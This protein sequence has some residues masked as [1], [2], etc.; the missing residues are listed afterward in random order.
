LSV[1]WFVAK[2][3]FLNSCIRRRQAGRADL[4]DRQHIVPAALEPFEIVFEPF[5]HPLDAFPWDAIRAVDSLEKVGMGLD[6][7]GD[8]PALERGRGGNELE[9]RVGDDDAI[10]LRGGGAGQEP[11]AL[12]PDEIGLVRNEDACARIEPQNSRLACARQ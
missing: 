10:P 5:L 3:S 4:V 1:V 7:I 11:L 8:Q 12:V 6:L 2:E 9:G